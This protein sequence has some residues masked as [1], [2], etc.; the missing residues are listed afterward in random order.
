VKLF[1]PGRECVRTGTPTPFLLLQRIEESKSGNFTTAD[2]KGVIWIFKTPQQGDSI[3]S[4][5]EWMKRKGLCERCSNR[6]ER[7]QERKL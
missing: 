4:G 5:S 6:V 7:I 2:G 1:P 3:P